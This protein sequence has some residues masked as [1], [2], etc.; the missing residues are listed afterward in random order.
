MKLQYG[1]II[2]LP[3]NNTFKI[4]KILNVVP[5][6]FDTIKEEWIV[7]AQKDT[8]HMLIIIDTSNNIDENKI[9]YIMIEIG[10]CENLY[11]LADAIVE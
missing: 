8:T 2:K 11:L 4:N 6:K 7:C 1:D 5:I 10:K 3:D 9:E